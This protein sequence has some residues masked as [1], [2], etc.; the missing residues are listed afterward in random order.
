MTIEEAIEEY[1]IEQT[2]RGNSPK[3]VADYRQK[4]RPFQRAT[5]KK[6]APAEMAGAKNQAVCMAERSRR[7]KRKTRSNLVPG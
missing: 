3:T 6:K 1:L 5:G 4:L 7:I 2:V